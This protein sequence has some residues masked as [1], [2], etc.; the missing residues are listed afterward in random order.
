MTDSLLR[1]QPSQARS[2]ARVDAILDAASALL[3]EAGASGTTITAVSE[4]IG[5]APSSVYEYVESDRQLIGAVAQRGLDA[6]HSDLVA[7]IGSPS[8]VEEATHALGKALDLFLDRY[9]S[10]QGLRQA[11]AFIDAD[12]ELAAINL[13][14]SRRNAAAFEAAIAPFRSGVDSGVTGLLLTHLTSA[15]AGLTLQVPA[16]EAKQ[17]VDAYRNLVTN[18]LST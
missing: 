6:L 5:I 4:R 14:D 15:L 17:L 13:A 12:P 8:S 7:T 1:R 16:D 18:L 3:S 11:L 9:H 2:K 10:A